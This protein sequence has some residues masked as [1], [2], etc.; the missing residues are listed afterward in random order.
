MALIRETIQRPVAEAMTETRRVASDQGYSFAEAESG[1][2]V[3]V[4][5]KRASLFSWG[6]GLRITFEATGPSATQLSIVTSETFAVTDWGRGK[7]AVRKLLD[8]LGAE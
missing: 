6:S 3:L 2:D 5:K 1:P 7:R 4:F 8:A